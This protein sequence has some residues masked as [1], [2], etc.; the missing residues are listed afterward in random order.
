MSGPRPMQDCLLP[1]LVDA[2]V[3]CI[4]Q[5]ALDDVREVFT[6]VAKGHPWGGGGEALLLR[7]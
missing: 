2:Q 4:Y 6:E 7:F 1:S 3:R 5:T